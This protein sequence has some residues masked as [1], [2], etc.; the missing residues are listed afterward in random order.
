MTSYI[1]SDTLGAE[2]ERLRPRGLAE[3]L[4]QAFRLYRRHFLTLLTVMVVSYVPVQVLFLVA[5]TAL[6]GDYG[7][8]LIIFLQDF[9]SYFSLAA[10]AVA[11]MGYYKGEPGGFSRTYQEVLKRFGPISGLIGMQGLFWLTLFVPA[12]LSSLV[13]VLGGTGVATD[14]ATGIGV[15]I[16]GLLIV[17]YLYVYVRFQ[18]AAPALIIERLSPVQALE[19]SWH[20]LRFSWWRTF[21]LIV[22]LNLLAIAVMIGPLVVVIG[23]LQVVIQADLA[24]EVLIT[25][26]VG[27][28]VWTLVAPIQMLA[29]ILYYIDLRVR[30]EG[31]DLESAIYGMYPNQRVVETSMAVEEHVKTPKVTPHLGNVE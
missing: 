22:L 31:F 20:L 3:I 7:S 18:V 21:R 19:R 6:L 25:N 11:V 26:V 16:L 5:D 12:I 29:T 23:I 1:S 8:T 13:A 4:D 2:I 17:P 15:I 14:T 27:T 28:L 24:T 9:L 30:N 10:L